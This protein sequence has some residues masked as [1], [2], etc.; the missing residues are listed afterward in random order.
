[1]KNQVS[2]T[3]SMPRN[4]KEDTVQVQVRRRCFIGGYGGGTKFWTTPALARVYAQQ[5]SVDV[6]QQLDT[7]PPPTAKVEQDPAYPKSSDARTLGLP[8][9]TASSSEGGPEAPSSVSAGGQVSQSSSAT[10]S[11][12]PASEGN[13]ASLPS[14]TPTSG[15]T[16]QTFFTSPMRSGGAGTKATRRTKRSKG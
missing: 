16:S 1:M 9:D 14:T 6:L 2:Q 3:L 8:T 15:V 4:R 5:G 12:A 10:M 13:A 7:T 11:D